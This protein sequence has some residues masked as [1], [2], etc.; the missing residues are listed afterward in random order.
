[1]FRP[2]IDYCCNC[3]VYFLLSDVG[4]LELSADIGEVPEGAVE[5]PENISSVPERIKSKF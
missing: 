1:M 2:F 3:F 4:D 5:N